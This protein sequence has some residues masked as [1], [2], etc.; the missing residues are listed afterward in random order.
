M[1]PE[2][3]AQLFSNTGSPL[4]TRALYQ[5]DDRLKAY[6]HKS[7]ITASPT[8]PLLDT[9]SP[10]EV[11]LLQHISSWGFHKNWMEQVDEEQLIDVDSYPS[12]DH[13]KQ[14]SFDSDILVCPMNREIMRLNALQPSVDRKAVVSMDNFDFAYL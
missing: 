5:V 13:H 4:T 2:N 11:A 3:V 10:D 6:L 7:I 1:C 9:L 8:S 14:Y 12:Y